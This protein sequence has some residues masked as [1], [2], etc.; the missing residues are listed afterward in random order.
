M[1][2]R[3]GGYTPIS[4]F[5]GLNYE[6]ESRADV[7]AGFENTGS[8]ITLGELRVKHG[9]EEIDYLPRADYLFENREVRQ[10][11]PSE[12]AA[13]EYLNTAYEVGEKRSY[14]EFVVWR[15]AK[16]EEVLNA[17]VKPEHRAKVGGDIYYG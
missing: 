9:G 13:L 8:L 10:G 16:N 6:Y 2:L 17:R 14:T 11:F 4:Y 1:E 7:T 15:T 5:S 12:A 3:I